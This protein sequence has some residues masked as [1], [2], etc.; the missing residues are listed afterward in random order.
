MGEAA[1]WSPRWLRLASV[2]LAIIVGSLTTVVSTSGPSA[3]ATPKGA[4]ILI[5]LI[6][7]ENDPVGSFPE[8][9][10]AVQAVTDYFNAHGGIHGRPIELKFCAT[11]SAPAQSAAC[12]N[13]M[14]QDHVVAVLDPFNLGEQAEVPIIDAAKIPDFGGGIAPNTYTA[15]YY[16]LWNSLYTLA[17]GEVAVTTSRFHAKRI[18]IIDIDL[19]STTGP[20][21]PL[22]AFKKMGVTVNEVLTPPTATD[23][24]SY[25]STA[26]ATHPQAL[27]VTEAGPGCLAVMD[28]LQSLDVKVP[29][30]S[31]PACFTTQLLAQAGSAA[32][33]WYSLQLGPFPTDPYV[34]DAALYKKIVDKY[35]NPP[36]F[37]DAAPS[38]FSAAYTLYQDILK[39]LPV[40]D[41]TAKTIHAKALSIKSGHEV[42]GTS[43]F[44]CGT[45]KVSPSV[46]GG[47][48]EYLYQDQNGK[49]VDV[50]KGKLVGVSLAAVS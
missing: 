20:G 3:A 32:Y 10:Y 6:V 48:G 15:P 41:I 5:G 2:G 28:G 14:V 37:G 16:T 23:Y 45:I 47:A 22:P 24:T 17:A 42:M 1:M 39:A 27:V 31:T 25:L 50:T 13:Q 29:I 40:N 35:E 44:P 43:L 8:A 26:L 33:G 36:N 11:T 49:P 12:A 9:Q 18:S 19:G 4:P 7:E 34:P 21:D 30:L 46:C 38:S